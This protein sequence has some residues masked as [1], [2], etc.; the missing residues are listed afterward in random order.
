MGA[1]DGAVRG[2]GMV[3]GVMQDATRESLGQCAA[4]LIMGIV[5]GMFIGE[6]GGEKSER[7]AWLDGKR[8]IVETPSG[9]V[10]EVYAGPEWR[11]AE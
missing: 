2:G 3:E 10:V 8:R 6:W 9:K 7:R 4:L 5:L 1:D 11:K